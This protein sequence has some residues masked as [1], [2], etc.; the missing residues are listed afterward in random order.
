MSVNV[1]EKREVSLPSLLVV[2]LYFTYQDM[3]C[4]CLFLN[5]KTK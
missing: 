4:L 1:R 3:P 5:L 2:L